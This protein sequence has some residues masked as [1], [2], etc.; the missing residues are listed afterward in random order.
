MAFQQ[1]IAKKIK[2]NGLMASNVKAQQAKLKLRNY[3]HHF[4]VGR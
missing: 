1:L 3:R 2:L 4:Y